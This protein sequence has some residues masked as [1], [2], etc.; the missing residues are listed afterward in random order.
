MQHHRQAVLA[1]QLELFAVEKFLALAHRALLE[2]RREIIEP[3]LAD[4]HQSRVVFSQ[5][6]FRIQRLQVGLPRLGHAQRVNAQRVAVRKPMRQQLRKRKIIK[7]RYHE[8]S[9]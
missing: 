3:D 2:R 7:R 9:N 6:Q 4:R 8:V 5:G 1:R